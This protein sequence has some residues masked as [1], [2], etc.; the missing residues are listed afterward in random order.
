MEKELNGSYIYD[1]EGCTEALF[2]A[3]VQDALTTIKLWFRDAHNI[4]L[5]IK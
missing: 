1:S 3:I 2:K 4:A 5:D